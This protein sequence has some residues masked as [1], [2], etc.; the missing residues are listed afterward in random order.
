MCRTLRN[1]GIKSGTTQQNSSLSRAQGVQRG[2]TEKG[3]MEMEGRGNSDFYRNISEELIQG[4]TQQAELI[5]VQDNRLE[6]LTGVSGHQHGG[7][8]QRKGSN[9]DLPPQN[10]SIDESLSDLNQH[11]I[12]NVAERG[13]QASKLYLAEAWFHSSQPMARSCSSELRYLCLGQNLVYSL[14]FM[15]PYNASS[16][17]FTTAQVVN[18]VS[19]G[20][21]M[22]KGTL[23]RKKLSNQVE[24]ESVEDSSLGY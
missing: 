1:E 15:S 9:G 17:T 5:I 12:R 8:L 16:S 6:E 22:L 4:T 20:V 10:I 24:K 21:S 23:E 14:T 3:I 2:E 11:S 18:T 7:L 13:V 19:S